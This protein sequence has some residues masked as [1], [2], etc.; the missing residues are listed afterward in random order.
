M[1]KLLAGLLCASIT[2]APGAVSATVLLLGG[3]HT[4]SGEVNDSVEAG[5]VDAPTTVEVTT[6]G[7][8]RQGV[9]M[10]GRSQLNMTGN[11]RVYANS[12]SRAMYFYG[13]TQT[14]F[15]GNS[16]VVGNVD[17]D[18]ATPGTRDDSMAFRRFVFQERAVLDGNFIA[19]GNVR[20]QDQ[21]VILGNVASSQTVNLIMTG[22]T[23]A[24][25]VGGSG[26]IY[27]YLDLSGGAVFDGLRYQNGWGYVDMSG[28]YLGG[29][30][31]DTT[32]RMEVDIS[33]GQIDGG[34]SH[35]SYYPGGYFS[36]TG[37]VINADPGDYLFHLAG[38]D[39]PFGSQSRLDLWGGQLG[40]VEAGLGIWLDN[41]IDLN[42]YGWGL[43]YTDGLLSGYLSDGNRFSSALTFGSNWSGQ[44]RLTDVSVPEPGTNSLLSIGLA[45]L[46]WRAHGSRRSRSGPICP[47]NPARA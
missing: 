5:A 1:R 36:I 22:G 34:I 46:A 23:V 32:G 2:A 20:I 37:G 27:H 10:R 4:I 24:G 45:L 15:G 3:N 47:A 13:P 6:G 33:G 18:D 29:H 39:A 25:F 9:T 41:A 7:V 11:G 44:L 31:I 16:R 42:I 30:G 28:G 43:A 26:N 40:Y 12:E 17:G 21:A 8:I 35:Y 38:S 19:S 14:T